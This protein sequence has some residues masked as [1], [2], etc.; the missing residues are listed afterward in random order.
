M[1]SGGLAIVEQRELDLFRIDAARFDLYPVYWIPA[2]TKG[3]Y[4]P[5]LQL[6]R[7]RDE[8]DDGRK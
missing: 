5:A 8:A 2:R 1:D 7:R 3:R 6:R 4:L